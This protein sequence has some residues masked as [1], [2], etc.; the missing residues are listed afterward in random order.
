MPRG[1]DKYKL[2]QLLTVAL[3]VAAADQATK[4]LVMTAI[5][6]Y[7]TVTVIPGFFNLTHIYNPG[8][9]FGFLASQGTAV[10]N[11]FFFSLSWLAILLV[12][13]FY[14]RTPRSYRLLSISFAMI[15]GGAIGNMIDRIRMG[16]VVDFLDLYIGNHHWPAFNVADSAI[17]V[18]ML[19]FVFHLL[20]RKMPD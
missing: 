18:G 11:I 10:R 2:I 16:H 9:A 13:Y 14:W 17:T 1:F 8:G 4:A 15:L 5:E 7:R 19:I 3:P 12:L 6:K 20:F